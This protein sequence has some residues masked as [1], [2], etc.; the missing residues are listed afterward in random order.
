MWML[1]LK[2]PETNIYIYI[3]LLLYNIYKIIEV[4]QKII[5]TLLTIQTIHE[6]TTLMY[7]VINHNSYFD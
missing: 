6:V 7:S 3:I 4:A 1:Y 2:H 5:F